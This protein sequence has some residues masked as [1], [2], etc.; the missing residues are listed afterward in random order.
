MKIGKD[1][2]QGEHTWFAWYPVKS[3]ETGKYL[4]LENV[5]VT[6]WIG[7]FEYQEEQPGLE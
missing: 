4:W 5:I 1:W 7:G 3:W 6:W 2:R